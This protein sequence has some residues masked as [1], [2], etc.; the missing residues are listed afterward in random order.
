MHEPYEVNLMDELTLKGI[1]Q[2]YA[3]VQERQ[4]VHC[5]N[6][7]FSKLQV[8]TVLYL[9]TVKAPLVLGKI[10]PYSGH[11]S[12]LPWAISIHQFNPGLCLTHQLFDSWLVYIPIFS[13]YRSTNQLY[14]AIPPNEW[15]FW[16]KRLQNQATAVITF[17]PKWPRHTETACSMISAPAYAG[18][19]SAQTFSHAVL[20]FR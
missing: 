20:T 15:S 8:I 1:T 2:Y 9:L 7:L 3:F 5:L 11:E 19:W 6:T 18:I 13:L 4:K 12:N 14:S 16:P 17:M 10:W